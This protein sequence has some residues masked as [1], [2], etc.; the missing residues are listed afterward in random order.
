MLVR[1]GRL[2][3][4]NGGWS[5][6]D[7]ACT[8]HDDMMNNMMVGHEFIVREFGEW[9]RPHVGWHIDPF[10]HSNANPRL[11]AE[12]GFDSWFF[13]RIDF[14]DKAERMANQSMQ[15][16]WKPF[17]QSL[18]DQVSIFTHCMPD[19]YHQPEQFRYDETN[20]GTDPV[21]TDPSLTTFNADEKMANLRAYILDDATHFRT[22]RLMIPW[23]DDFNYSNAHL[24]FANL[25]NTIN[26]FNQKYDDITLLY[27]TPSEYVAALKAQDIKWPVR[28]DDMF[29]YADQS[30]DYWTGYFTSRADAKKQDRQTQ[31]NFHASAKLSAQKLLQKGV[32]DDTVQ[33]VLDMK[34]TMMNALGIMQHHD[35][36][37][38]TAKQAVANNYA[39]ILDSAVEQNNTLYASLIAEKAAQAGLAET[40]D[41]KACSLTSTSPVDCGKMAVGQ[42][43]LVTA[44]NPSTVKQ[45]LLRFVADPTLTYTVYAMKGQT[46]E[47]V[48][49]DKLC[50]TGTLDDASGTKQDTCELFVKAEVL[51]HD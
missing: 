43:W 18:G 39:Q 36:I 40:L 19:H 24:T 16:V 4:V 31:A 13:A 10:G 41:W 27:S 44:H 42:T 29:P 11:F 37:T 1:Q 50:Y 38:G 21:V 35:A 45:E 14:E 34:H 9:A 47:E 49:S 32:S 3:F 22:N 15:W 2:E 25:E 23:G 12:M 5:M 46:W 26:Y 48:P 17:A 8:H 7:E 6:H 30:E 33:S 28:Y 20:F 51:P